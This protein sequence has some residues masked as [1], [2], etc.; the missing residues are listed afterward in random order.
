M[1]VPSGACTLRSTPVRKVDPRW[2]VLLVPLPVVSSLATLS[3]ESI[4]YSLPFPPQDISAPR[5]DRTHL[6]FPGP[7]KRPTQDRGTLDL[8]ILP[9]ALR[10]KPLRTRGPNLLLQRFITLLVGI[11]TTLV[12]PPPYTRQC[13]LLPP[14]PIAAVTGR[15]LRTSLRKKWHPLPLWCR[16]LLLATLCT[17]VTIQPSPRQITC[18]VTHSPLLS[19]T[20]TPRA[21]SL[22]AWAPSMCNSDATHPWYLLVLAIKP[23]TPRIFG[24]RNGSSPVPLAGAPSS[25][26]ITFRSPS[27]HIGT[28]TVWTT[29]SPR[30][31]HPRPT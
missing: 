6:S 18:I 22:E 2:P 27:R 28:L 10:T 31:P 8:L 17:K 3:V 25:P 9:L 12:V 11:L 30:S 20:S 26:M 23:P 16:I 13:F 29:R 21:R 19:L 15:P 1:T 7:I 24:P 14:L 5:N 4:T